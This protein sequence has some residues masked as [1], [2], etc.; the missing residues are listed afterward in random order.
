M[1][2]MPFGTHLQ[3][4][5]SL[6]KSDGDDDAR[7]SFV[8]AYDRALRA[9]DALNWKLTTASPLDSARGVSKTWIA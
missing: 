1:R 6:T 4:R 7:S 9:F 8:Q 5:F 3:A 2:S